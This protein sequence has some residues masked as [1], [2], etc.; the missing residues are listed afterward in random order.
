MKNLILI[1]VFSISISTIGY[2]GVFDWFQS[3]ESRLKDRSQEL[4]KD[5]PMVLDDVTVWVGTSSYKNTLIYH[6]TIDPKIF[7]IYQITKTQWE[8]VHSNFLKNSFCTDP[9]SKWFKDNNVNTKYK[10]SYL[11]GK[12][13]VEIDVNNS[14]CTN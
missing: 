4:N 13:L 11:D 14:D 10:Y 6:Y 5:L 3:I 9:D 1:S 8:K 12:F 2:C 7:S